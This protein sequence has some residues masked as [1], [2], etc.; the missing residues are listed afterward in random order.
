MFQKVKESM[1]MIKK[2]RE[3][4]KTKSTLKIKNTLRVTVGKRVQK[5]K[6]NKCKGTAIKSPKMKDCKI[7]EMKEMN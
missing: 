7:T 4:I 6:M 3:D 1:S 2:E 5:K